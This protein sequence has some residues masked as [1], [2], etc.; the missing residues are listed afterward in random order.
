[1]LPLR[2]M[3]SSHTVRSKWKL[4]QVTLCRPVMSICC[5]ASPASL[6][7]CS[8]QGMLQCAWVSTP[9]TMLSID[10]VQVSWLPHTMGAQMSHSGLTDKSD[11]SVIKTVI[12]SWTG[13]WVHDPMWI[14]ESWDFC[15]NNYKRG[16]YFG[17]CKIVVCR[18]SLIIKLSWDSVEVTF[19]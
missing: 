15:Q 14:N 3:L 17:A 18:A 4:I 1:M 16:I 11:C 9:P 19:E 12:G 8:V 5:C 2:K 13:M 10:A 6:S 7:Y